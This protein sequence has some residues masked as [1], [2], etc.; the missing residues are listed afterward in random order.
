MKGRKNEKVSV[1]Y[2]HYSHRFH[3]SGV[4]LAKTVEG[5]KSFDPDEKT[6]QIIKELNGKEPVS[7]KAIEEYESVKY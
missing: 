5:L 1:Y 7:V 3:Y 6:F 4:C 2:G